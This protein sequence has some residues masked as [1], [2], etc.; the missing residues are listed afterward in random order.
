MCYSE[1]LSLTSLSFGLFA[2]LMLLGFGNKESEKSNKAIGYFFMFVTLMQLVE[3]FLWIDQDCVIGYNYVGSAIGPI[4]N[5]LQ[6]VVMLLFATK[7]MESADVIPENRLIFANGLYLM[8]IIY[9]YIEYASKPSNLCVET[10]DDNHLDWTWK[11]NFDYIFYFIIS[12]IN[13]VNFYKNTNFVIAM[14]IGYLFLVISIFKFDKNIG[15]F[16]C[17]MVTGVPLISLFLQKTL[18][19]DN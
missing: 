5:N 6:P 13:A 11:A 12:F 15:E 10:N 9:K 2:S 17:L 16:W 19:I 14:I 7:F 1:E 18:Y 3:Y 8:Y 4:L